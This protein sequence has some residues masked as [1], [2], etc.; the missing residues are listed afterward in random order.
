MKLGIGTILGPQTIDIVDLAPRVEDLGFESIWT[1]EQA[2]LPVQTADPIPREWGNIPDPF[3]LLSRAAAVTKTLKLGTAVVVVTEHHPITLAKAVG[4]LDM[5]S[6]GR[7]VFG[8]G[9]G[10]HPEEAEIFGVDFA[11]RWTQAC[12]AISAIKELWTQDI[13]EHH[14]AYYDFPPVYCYPKPVQK[15]YPPILLGSMVPQAFG[16]VVAYADGWIPIGVTSDKIREGRQILDELAANAGRD[17]NS[18][19]ITTFSET[20]DIVD[21]QEQIEAGADRI[22]LGLPSAGRD[23]SL[24]A[25]DAIAVQVKDLL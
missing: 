3:V 12:E 10:S 8:I 24:L 14:G 17:P 19:D 16:R 2:T 22:I 1:G 6:K 4:S 25:L 11:H 18:I 13:S 9:I 5:Y 7:L 20:N 21:I 15:P 23:E